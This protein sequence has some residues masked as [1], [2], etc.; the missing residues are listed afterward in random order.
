MEKRNKT[1]RNRK[2]TF[3]RILDVAVREFAAKGFDG[4]RVDEIAKSADVSKNL[5]YHYFEDKDDLFL[6]ALEQ[7]YSQMRKSQ[8]KW[9][10]DTLSPKEGIEKLVRLTFQH[11]A[12]HPELISLINSENQHKARHLKKS[13]FIRELYPKLIS[14][15]EDMLKRGAQEGQFRTDVDP[16]DLYLSI[17]GLSYNYLSNRH[18]LQT[19][20]A[21]NFSDK[22]R[23]S[24]RLDHIVD[25]ILS[26]L[27]LPA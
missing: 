26:F 8:D 12:K 25:V 19:I 4:A 6:H 27:R 13:P 11:L 7:V 18:T 16:I 23:M 1:V 3:K 14:G 17:Q 24:Q 20:F 21:Q 5:I 2:A 9:S 15:I 10:F 22:T